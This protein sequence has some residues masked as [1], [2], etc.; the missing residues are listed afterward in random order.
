MSGLEI[1]NQYNT[2]AV[3]KYDCPS[4]AIRW[5]WYDFLVTTQK[6]P[7]FVKAVGS[8]LVFDIQK[9]SKPSTWLFSCSFP[10][11]DRRTETCDLRLFC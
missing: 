1:E 5:H 9:V 7:L 8:A 11:N 4:L 6:C 10:G 3:P 2:F